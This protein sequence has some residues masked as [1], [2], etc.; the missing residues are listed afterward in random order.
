MKA[1]VVS[2]CED[3]FFDTDIAT[4]WTDECVNEFGEHQMGGTGGQ[5]NSIAQRLRRERLV[6]PAA[7]PFHKRAPDE[8][9]NTGSILIVTLL[10]SLA[11]WAAIW[12]TVKI[13][14]SALLE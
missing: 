6:S 10:L 1:I 3:P 13:S 2:G 7:E 12:G 8:R 5:R 14:A 4:R 11:L 9:P